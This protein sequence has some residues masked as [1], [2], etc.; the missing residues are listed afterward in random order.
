M[1]CYTHVP[2]ISRFCKVVWEL[3]VSS[4]R[5]GLRVLA[6][7]SSRVQYHLG[8]LSLVIF[9]ALENVVQSSPLLMMVN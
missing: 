7:I 9:Y 6:E 5:Q 4:S 3:S 8:S 2:I 1:H